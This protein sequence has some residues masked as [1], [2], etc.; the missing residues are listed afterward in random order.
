MES[1]NNAAEL[2]L[3]VYILATTLFSFF[4]SM[5]VN[6]IPMAGFDFSHTAVIQ[7]CKTSGLIAV[8]VEPLWIMGYLMR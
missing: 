1:R 3:L 4:V 7:A 6:I 5:A 2:N 8:V